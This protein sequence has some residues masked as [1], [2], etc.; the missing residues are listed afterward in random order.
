MCL[1]GDEDGGGDDGVARAA[2]GGQPVSAE[3]GSSPGGGGP[4]PALL[5]GLEVPTSV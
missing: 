5:P 4:D 1:R 2:E 3:T